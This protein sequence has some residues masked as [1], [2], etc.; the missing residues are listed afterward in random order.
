MSEKKKTLKEKESDLRELLESMIHHTIPITDPRF[1]QL[2]P[3]MSAQ[4]QWEHKLGNIQSFRITRR[5]RYK[6]LLLQIKVLRCNRWL[7][8][9]WKNGIG[10]TKKEPDPLISAFRNAIRRQCSQWGRTHWEDRKCQECESTELL[11]V[12][13]TDPQFKQIRTEFVNH[14]VEKE[15]KPP[16]EFRKGH[17]GPRFLATDVNYTR[18]WQRYHKEKARY[19]WLCRSCNCR[20][21]KL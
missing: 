15:I 14:C 12:D 17:R 9:S 5:R 6:S 10:R 1:Q 18:K 3:I 13:H 8:V 16:T 21:A 2:L 4:S 11:Q 19:Q 20:K 7:T